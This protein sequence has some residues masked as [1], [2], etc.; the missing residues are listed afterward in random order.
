MRK[1]TI[2]RTT[3]ETQ[4]EITLSLDGNGELTG[5]TSI[6]FFDHMLTAL[7]KYAGFDMTLVCQGDL[8]IDDHH[9]V[10]DVGICLGQAFVKAL[11]NKTGISRFGHSYVPL[12]EALARAVVDISGRSHLAF[13]A[14]FSRS[15]IGSFSTEMVHEFFKAFVDHACITMHLD[16]L[17]GVNSH[18]QVEAL[19]KA[20]ARALRDAVSFDERIKGI[21]STKGSL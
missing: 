10:E 11:G 18:H 20:A 3:R 14:D 8:H 2:E 1:A 12:D 9:T 15:S 16:L 21:P 7:T 4:I 5:Q 6:G 19:F 13:H 17:T